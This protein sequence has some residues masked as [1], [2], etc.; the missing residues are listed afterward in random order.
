[1]S[2]H[3]DLLERGAF[4]PE[5]DGDNTLEKDEEIKVREKE[6]YKEKDPEGYSDIVLD[7]A[8]EDILEKMTHGN[9]GDPEPTPL[10]KMREQTGP[11]ENPMRKLDHSHYRD[12]NEDV[13]FS[14]LIF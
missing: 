14:S 6:L 2:F 5:N 13:D 4:T 11:Q 7:E 1:M 9:N 10:E 8:R 12:G 3:E